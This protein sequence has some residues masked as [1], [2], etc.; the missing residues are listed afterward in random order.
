MRYVNIKFSERNAY[1]GGVISG[2]VIVQT[3]S[4]FDCNRI[5]LKVKGKERTEMGSGD[6]KISDEFIHASGW[7]VL[8]DATRV[9]AGTS[10][11]PFRF[12]LDEDLPPTYSGYNGWIEYSVE[13]VVEMD[14]AI[15]P[16]TTRRFRVL[17][18]PPNYIPDKDG[19]DPKNKKSGILSVELLSNVV[20]MQQGI[21]VRFM[22]EEH[23]RVNGVRLEIRRQEYVRCRGRKHTHDV[24]IKRK[25]IPLSDRDFDRW[26]EEVV[27]E[28]WRR[29][30]F[31]SRLLSTSYFLRIVLEMRWE[32]DPFVT[33]Q[34][35]VSGETPKEEVED[36]LD[37]LAFD[38]GFN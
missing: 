32:I 6:S 35:K 1:P 13:A 33:F 27:G 26:K 2:I 14:W 24:T 29:V 10:E 23:S 34:L 21:P 19:Y 16:K 18:T 5:I 20:R 22:V 3:D 17:P 31:S 4:S 37:S 36:V 38:F 9:R 11:F 25:F 7:M 12:Q 28:G 30:P 15:D 8:S